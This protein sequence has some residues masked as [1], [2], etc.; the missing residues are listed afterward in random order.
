M[1]QSQDQPPTKDRPVLETG[2][3]LLRHPDRRD[4]ESIIAIAGDWEV[5]HRLARIPHPYGKK[6]ADFF[7]DVI[8]PNEW[9]WPI[10]WRRSGAL[11]GMAGLSPDTERDVA[12]LG[13]YV[14]RRHWDMGVAT[15]A[16]RAVVTYGRQVLGLRLI[17][18]GY[19]LDNPASGRV[20]AKLGF[21]EA[22]C[23]ERP[24]LAAGS[25][26]AAVD[27]HLQH[28]GNPL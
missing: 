19:F 24:C 10:T 14:E 17:T 5:A 12:E 21:V 6:D 4:A 16:A 27:M 9:V 11:I 28:G 26:V 1:G 13:Y 23:S 25:T 7:I 18:S 3:L 8:V 22:G 15:E 20:L 2:R